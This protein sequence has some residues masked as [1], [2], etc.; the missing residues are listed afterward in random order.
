MRACVGPQLLGCQIMCAS[1]PPAPRPCHT[2]LPNATYRLMQHRFVSTRSGRTK[3]PIDH[4]VPPVQYLTNPENWTVVRHSARAVGVAALLSLTHPVIL[5]PLASTSAVALTAVHGAVAVYMQRATLATHVLS[6][7][8]A[9]RKQTLWSSL[10]V[11]GRKKKVADEKTRHGLGVLV[12]TAV[13]ACITG[14]A[15]HAQNAAKQIAASFEAV[16]RPQQRNERPLPMQMAAIT[17]PLCAEKVNANLAAATPTQ[18]V[19]TTVKI[20]NKLSRRRQIHVPLVRVF[21]PHTCNPVRSRLQ[22]GQALG[23]GGK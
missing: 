21:K 17:S 6:R 22:I 4:L 23:P 20:E 8:A 2:G 18:P 5:P 9:A 16:V 3:T 7:Q 15:M 19:T 11:L 13:T 1:I 10:A 12:T 14:G